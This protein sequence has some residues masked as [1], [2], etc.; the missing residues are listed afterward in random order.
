MKKLLA[1]LL[2][3]MMLLSACAL[4]D[5]E[6]M[7]IE[8]R[9]VVLLENGN[10]A[11]DLSVFSALLQLGVDGDRGGM[12]LS[13]NFADRELCNVLLAMIGHQ[14]L[15]EV[16]ADGAGSAYYLD[17]STVLGML[18]EMIDVQM[19]VESFGEAFSGTDSPF[20][21]FGGELGQIFAG[22]V[23]DGGRQTIGNVEYNVA[24]VNIAP[25]QM[26]KAIET[27]VE[28]LVENGTYTRSEADETLN[29]FFSLGQEYTLYGAIYDSPNIGIINLTFT[30]D[31]PGLNSPFTLNFFLAGGGDAT[32]GYLF[33]ISLGASDGADSYGISFD[34]AAQNTN[35]L[36]WLPSSVGS[37]R[38][39]LTVNDLEGTLSRDFAAIGDAIVN[40]MM[41]IMLGGGA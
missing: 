31:A 36:S 1:V 15:L 27:L 33:N 16:N 34:I 13:L 3:V 28:M 40:S 29:N 24:S 14:I 4:A 11:A 9:N 39:I 22:S 37:A 8:V 30:M 18:G 23:S 41:G 7:E 19:V 26:R 12:K 10:A 35:D 2:A 20:A 21:A 25:A 38:D 5:S 32:T 17:L 6:P